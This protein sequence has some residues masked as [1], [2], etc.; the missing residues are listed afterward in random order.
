MVDCGGGY[1]IPGPAPAP[2]PPPAQK[3]QPKVQPAPDRPPPARAPV[4][5]PLAFYVAMGPNG[6]CM[7]LGPDNPGPYATITAWLSSVHYP[8]CP[9]I[10][11]SAKGTA[12]PPR[13]PL[14]PLTLAVR[15][16]RTIPLPVPRPTIPPGYAVTGKAAYLVTDGTT[17]PP[18]FA[19]ATPL[20]PLVVVATGRYLVNWGDP[21]APG[22]AGPYTTEGRPWPSGRITHVY[23]YT[24]TDTVT[25]VEDW[26]A[27]WTLAGATGT[28]GGLHT[29]ATIPAFRVEQLQAVLTN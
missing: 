10:P 15:F 12:A 23:D 1:V 9:P 8:S 19:E 17:S 27:T 21:A 26:T 14:N 13:P 22:W 4:V 25:V 7:V 28:L 24:G 2:T 5:T 16:W 20:G 6:P 11:P 3:T 18:P 29:V